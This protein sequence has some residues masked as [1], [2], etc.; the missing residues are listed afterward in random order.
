MRVIDFS[1]VQQQILM[2]RA[3]IDSGMDRVTLN[4]MRS[5]LIDYLRDRTA[6]LIA[7]GI[8]NDRAEL[9]LL[10]TA[11]FSIG[12]VS[13]F[14]ESLFSKMAYNQNKTRSRLSDEVTSAILHVHDSARSN[15]LKPLTGEITLQVSPHTSDR[16]DMEKWVG[17]KVCDVFKNV[18]GDDQRFHGRV[19]KVVEH[20]VYRQWMYRVV[21]EDS[22]TVDYWR[23]EL[24]IKFCRCVH[25]VA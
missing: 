11:I 15:P 20:D 12:L 13:A 1:K 18:D 14:V 7:V 21:Y 16:V 9:D 25:L 10:R 19:Q 4:K 17:A 23:H 2:E 5:N 3:E 22:D 8:D 24:E 6:G